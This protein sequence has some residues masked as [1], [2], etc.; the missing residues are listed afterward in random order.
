MIVVT[1]AGGPGAG[2]RYV[3]DWLGTGCTGGPAM[4]SPRLMISD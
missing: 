4:A 2:E 1:G 3:T